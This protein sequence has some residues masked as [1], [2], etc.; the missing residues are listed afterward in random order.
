M[1]YAV[2]SY[3][4]P[5]PPI[6]SG[7]VERKASVSK[8][9]NE[10]Q[11]W[12]KKSTMKARIKGTGAS[13]MILRNTMKFKLATSGCFG[14]VGRK[15]LNPPSSMPTTAVLGMLKIRSLLPRIS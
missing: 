11:N 1:K 15:G 7:Q 4:F 3:G 14:S 9:M 8:K 12:Q 6:I 5:D 10:S 2:R 13:E